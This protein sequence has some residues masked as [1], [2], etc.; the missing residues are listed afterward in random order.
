MG[1]VGGTSSG[2]RAR[3][4]QPM[5]QICSRARARRAATHPA[6]RAQLHELAQR[7]AEQLAAREKVEGHWP[8]RAE[9]VVDELGEAVAR[10]PGG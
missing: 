1:R 7:R 6:Q 4:G 9:E 2:P 8:R 10:E 5:V 3:A